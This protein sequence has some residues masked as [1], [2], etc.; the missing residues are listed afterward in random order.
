[1]CQV[2]LKPFKNICNLVMK[3]E[4]TF[5]IL[6]FLSHFRTCFFISF[7]VYQQLMIFDAMMFNLFKAIM[8]PM[9]YFSRC[10]L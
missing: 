10:V 6:L 7:F 3:T 5:D 8:N 4:V 2:Y 1:M 9:A